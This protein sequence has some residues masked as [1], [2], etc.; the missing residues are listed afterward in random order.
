MD[1]DNR[2]VPVRRYC[3]HLVADGYLGR[4]RCVVSTVLT[5][6]ATK[7]DN[8]I[9]YWNWVSLR[10]Q[11]GGILGASL[12][13]HHLDLLRYTFGEVT[14]IGGVSTTQV[15]DKP[16][17]APGYSEW[18][19]LG[20]DTPIVGTRACDAEDAVAVHGRPATGGLFHMTASWSTH[21]V[22]AFGSR[23]TGRKTPSF[24]APTESCTGPGERL[25][26]QPARGPRLVRAAFAGHRVATVKDAL[27]TR[28]RRHCVALLCA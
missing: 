14:D 28:R 3:H 8:R 21:P 5:G 26:P 15:T 16:V 11:A 4:P 6:Y 17:L 19:E 23:P 20:P 10:A 22:P 1:L 18:S 2:H 9:Y 25:R 12:R 7:P 27:M 24:S 13:L